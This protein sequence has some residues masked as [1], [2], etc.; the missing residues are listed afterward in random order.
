MDQNEK[1]LYNMNKINMKNKITIY[2]NET[3]P[4]CAQV[5]KELNEKEIKFELKLTKDFKSE[6]QGVFNLTG[7]ATVPTIECNG[8]YFVPNRDFQNPQ[9]LIS[10]L[11]HYKPST[12]SETKIIL[13]KLKTLNYNMGMA[14]VR[15]DKLLNKP[16]KINTDEHKST[17]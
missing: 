4:Y 7:M 1:L 17:D 16:T 2:T 6:W 11:E 3:C 10:M 13:E 5:I 9:Q 12:Y 8:E 15:L 14:F